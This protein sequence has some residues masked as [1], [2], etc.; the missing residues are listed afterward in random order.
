LDDLFG[1]LSDDELLKVVARLKEYSDKKA[2]QPVLE[3][4]AVLEETIEAEERDYQ[5]ENVKEL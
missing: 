5:D 1:I 3:R 2:D 4:F